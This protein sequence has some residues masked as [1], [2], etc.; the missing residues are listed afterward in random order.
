MH[1]AR[2]PRSGK[3]CSENKGMML[4]VLE[5]G[6]REVLLL[7]VGDDLQDD[8]PVRQRRLG[9]QVRLAGGAPAELRPQEE[10]SEVLAD[11]GEIGR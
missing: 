4:R 2:S 3:V 10:R 7:V 6:E 8:R 1:S 5:P 11:L 9:G